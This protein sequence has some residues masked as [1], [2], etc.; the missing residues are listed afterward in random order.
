MSDRS[1]RTVDIDQVRQEHLAEVDEAVHWAYLVGVLAFGTIL[2]L[3]MIAWL[4]A[5]GG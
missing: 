5:A 2:M 1:E 4:G 3:V